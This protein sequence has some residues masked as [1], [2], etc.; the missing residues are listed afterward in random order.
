MT[1]ILFTNVHI[2]LSSFFPVPMVIV[3][4]SIDFDVHTS[5]LKSAFSNSMKLTAA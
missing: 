1:I 4:T 5:K 3:I 2:M